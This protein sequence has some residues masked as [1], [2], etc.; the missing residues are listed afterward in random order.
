MVCSKSTKAHIWCPVKHPVVIWVSHSI[1]PILLWV[2]VFFDVFASHIIPLDSGHFRSVLRLQSFRKLC[3][4]AQQLVSVISYTF[5]WIFGIVLGW[6]LTFSNAGIAI[7]PILL[8]CFEFPRLCRPILFHPQSI[9]IQC[10][11]ISPIVFNIVMYSIDMSCFGVFLQR[12]LVLV[13]W[14]LELV[15]CILSISIFDFFNRILNWRL[16]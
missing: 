1:W 8:S 6:T 9:P 10:P 2:N 7:W 4:V 13:H 16:L 15:Y 5:E 3:C 12:L 11:R 14:L